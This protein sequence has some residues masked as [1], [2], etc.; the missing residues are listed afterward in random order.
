MLRTT[1]RTTTDCDV[2]F[3][4]KYCIMDL[5]NKSSA[6][7]ST[8]CDAPHLGPGPVRFDWHWRSRGAQPSRNS[9]AMATVTDEFLRLLYTLQ[10]TISV[11]F[12]DQ[13][14]MALL[15]VSRH[16]SCLRVCCDMSR[17]RDCRQSSIWSPSDLH[18]G[19]FAPFNFENFVRISATCAS[20]RKSH[21]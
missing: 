6:E 4:M 1:L 10:D 21:L 5:R 20:T 3:Q 14:R 13:T 19:N 17:T 15:F 9:L 16:R 8:K 2:D 12:H 18:L 11:K 7:C